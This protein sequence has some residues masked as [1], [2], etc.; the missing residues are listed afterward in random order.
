MDPRA[1][2]AV[3]NGLGQYHL[4]QIKDPADPNRELIVARD[5]V[6]S[7]FPGE[8]GT[9]YATGYNA[10]TSPDASFLGRAWVMRGTPIP[11]AP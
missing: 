10:S 5:I 11:V 1:Y 6:G 7:P 3:R 2:F 9:V 8:R 4:E